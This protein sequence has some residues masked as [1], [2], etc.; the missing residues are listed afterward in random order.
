MNSQAAYGLRMCACVCVVCEQITVR[1]KKLRKQPDIF[2][3]G[4]LFG[5]PNSE[6]LYSSSEY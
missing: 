5:V 6:L 2:T 3:V 1:E 4:K